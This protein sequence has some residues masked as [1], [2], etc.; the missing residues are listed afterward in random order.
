MARDAAT[1]QQAHRAATG[2]GTRVMAHIGTVLRSLYSGGG[3]HNSFKP[4]RFAGRLNSGFRRITRTPNDLGRW[5][6]QARRY[7]EQSRRR[8]R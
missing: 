6:W 8:S 2:R 3:P 7:S 4:S 1:A 5:L